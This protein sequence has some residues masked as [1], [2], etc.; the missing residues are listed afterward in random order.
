MP[1]NLLLTKLHRRPSRIVILFFCFLLTPLWANSPV[2]GEGRFRSQEGDSSGLINGQLLYNAFRNVITKELV[3]MKLDSRKFWENYEEKFNR[4]FN[5][6]EI[7]LRK[8]SLDKKGKISRE[9]RKELEKIIRRRKLLEKSTHGS[10]GKF[11]PSYSIKKRIRPSSRFPH[12]HRIVIAARVNRRTLHQ[13]YVSYTTQQEGGLFQRLFISVDFN[14]KNLDL[15]EI[16]INRE[17][18][19]TRLVEKGWKEWFEKNM[20]TLFREVVISDNFYDR[21][22]NKFLEL[23]KEE[24]AALLENKDSMDQTR[25]LLSESLWLK[26]NVSIEKS[27]EDKILGHGE[28]S[29][30]MDYVCLDLRTNLPVFF[31]DNI[32]ETSRLEFNETGDIGIQLS[33]TVYRI[34]LGR[35]EKISGMNLSSI[36]TN[37]IEITVGNVGNMLDLLALS[38]YI[39]NRGVVHEIIPEISRYNVT[40]AVITLNFRGKREEIL[41]FLK[42]LDGNVFTAGKALDVNENTRFHIRKVL[43]NKGG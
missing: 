43:G 31:A 34:P 2:S 9:K 33:R 15:S 40:T 14:I 32:A 22:I 30:K 42:G 12:S 25:S 24:K 37:K 3:A 10:L 16:G 36:S 28:F 39:S 29:V 23:P 18:D 5:P 17:R 21:E 27:G 35:F 19:F 1:L 7:A 6:I 11:V 41:S 4:H 38:E 26:I 20:G 13:T 8:K